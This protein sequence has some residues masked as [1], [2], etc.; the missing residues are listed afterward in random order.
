VPVKVFAFF[1]FLFVPLL[2]CNFRQHGIQVSAL[3]FVVSELGFVLFF[4]NKNVIK[5][6]KKIRLILMNEGGV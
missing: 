2:T 3:C 6:K 4:V 1:L 5:K